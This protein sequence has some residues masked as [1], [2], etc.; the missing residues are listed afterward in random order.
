VTGRR[1]LQRPG[2]GLSLLTLAALA[3]LLGLGIWQ[4][5]RLAW[6]QGLIDA[7]AARMAA[8]ALDLPARLDPGAAAGLDYRHVRLAGTYLHDK[9]MHLIATS[10]HGNAGYKVITPLLRADG[11]AVL[12][13]RGWVPPDRRDPAT[14]P[15]SLALGPVTVE[16]VARL[17]GPPG[18]F[19]PDNDPARNQWYFVEPPAM[20]AWA[21]LDAVLPVYVE[22][23]AAPDAAADADAETLPIGGQ[24]RAALPNP[25]LGY[26]ITWFG[27]AAALAAVFV[28]YH[29]R[30]TDEG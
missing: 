18:Y 17:P 21:G 12:V 1:R 16:G 2:L 30:R 5:K 28:I 11:A 13:S 19:T 23:D 7:M 8:P 20:A 3:V 9:E 29:W 14:R 4:M 6:K 15:R 25:H 10:R 27:I 22:A 26:A 24:V